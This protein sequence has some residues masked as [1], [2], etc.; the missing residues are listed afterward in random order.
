MTNKKLFATD[1]DGT[2]CQ[3]PHGVTDEYIEKILEF[4]KKGNIFGIITGR[5]YSNA[6]IILENYAKYC[7]FVMCMTGAYAEDPDG[8]KIFEYEGDGTI[9]PDILKT[10]VDMG[11]GYLNYSDG[12]QTFEI[13][14]D[15]KLT[16]DSDEIIEAKRHMNFSQINTCFDPEDHLKE[17]VERLVNLYGDKINPQLN[18]HC[19][20]IPPSQV[21]KGKAVLRMAEYFG[22]DAD[23]IYT[24][25][26]NDNDLSM[27]QM[28]HGFTVPHG[29]PA[30]KAAAE[31]IKLN[32]AEMLDEIMTERE[33]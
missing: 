22:V 32:V 13:D 15:A 20:D 33:S 14:P 21:S 25:G 4:R 8:N 6:G 12:K 16:D 5:A 19:V 23:N 26:D 24:A 2:L 1:F 30:C 17:C 3:Y 9:L 7:D 27:I 18:G 28:H 11:C 31:K 10:I 29:S